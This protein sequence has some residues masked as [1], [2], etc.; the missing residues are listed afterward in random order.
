M[1]LV[2]VCSTSTVL[3][4]TITSA[5]GS[6]VQNVYNS[7]SSSGTLSFETSGGNIPCKHIIFRPWT[8][9]NNVL[10]SLKQS[11][12]LFVESVIKYAIRHD[13]S[14]IGSFNPYFV[15][16]GEHIS[17]QHFQVLAVDNWAMIQK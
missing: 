13:L 12:E 15:N 17:F 11:I 16:N 7:Q 2:V 14:T 6:S 9:T 4:D 3:C 10:Q 5:A 8:Y 1:D